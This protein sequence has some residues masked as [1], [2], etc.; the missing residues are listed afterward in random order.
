MSP[1]RVDLFNNIGVLAGN[2]TNFELDLLG[3]PCKTLDPFLSPK[4]N[5]FTKTL[6]FMAA[7]IAS[8]ES[9]LSEEAVYKDRLGVTGGIGFNGE[10]VESI[11]L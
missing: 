1:L 10:F 7:L 3:V 11:L 5:S 9:S 6:R 2:D 4:F 8:N